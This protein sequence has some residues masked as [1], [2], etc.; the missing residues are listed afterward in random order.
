MDST[1]FKK[2]FIESIKT[3]AAV[4]GEGSCASFVDNM[5][6]YL[7]DAEALSDF[8]PSFYKGKS[9][10]SNYRVHLQMYLHWRLHVKCLLKYQ[11][12]INA[13]AY[14]HCYAKPPKKAL[15]LKR[16]MEELCLIQ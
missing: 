14:L 9:G 7:I 10:R 6:Q 16:K 8:T 4:T 5:A 3:A 1:E 2:D 12:L 15:I 11:T 13:N